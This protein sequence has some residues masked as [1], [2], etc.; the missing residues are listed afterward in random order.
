MSVNQNML[1]AQKKTELEIRSGVEIPMRDGT[2]LSGNLYLPRALPAQAPAIFGM[3]PYTADKH[4][5]VAARISAEGFPFLNVDVRGSGKSQGKSGNIRQWAQDGYDVAQWLASQPF[6]DGRV[7]M[8]GGSIRGF[9]QWA[10]AKERPPSLATIIPVASCF[11]GLDVPMRNNVFYS[12]GGRTVWSAIS[13]DLEFWQM[14]YRRWLVAGKPFS[15]I[16]TLIGKADPKFREAL[17]HP[18]PDSHWDSFNPSADQY[19]KID[20]PILTITGSYD[21][22][23]PGALEHY[24]QH[25]AHASESARCNHYLVIGPW[26]HLGTGVPQ[27]NVGGVAI[28][29]NG[30]ID[31]P[32]LLADWYRWRLRAG[33]KPGLLK[34]LVTY[35]VM[36]AD[37]WKWADTLDEITVAKKKLFLDSTGT[38]SD[39]YASGSLGAKIGKGPPDS[40][41]YDPR[42]R[43]GLEVDEEAR[44]DIKPYVDQS[45]F[46]ALHSRMLVYHSAPFEAEIEVS[47]FFKL[48]AW[49]S[50]DAPDTDLYASVHEITLDGQSIQLSTD[51]IRARYRQGLRQP[52]L[53]VN[54]DPLQYRFERFTFVS[55]RIKRGHRIRLVISPLGRIVDAAINQRNYNS[56]GAV[57]HESADVGRPVTVTL[58]HNE[59]FPSVLVVPLGTL[60]REK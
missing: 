9:N 30:V 57:A 14:T 15:Q 54:Q 17:Q 32:G 18:E 52:S 29:A 20:I 50:I 45:L 28:G 24:R 12:A 11:F 19:S 43:S 26:D 1:G 47:G 58:F 23:Q 56:G 31:M 10:T 41:T 2:L 49:L 13:E 16:D 25:I 60:E 34:K 38:A 51:V 36:G 5:A 40:Y 44:I 22:D 59:E 27:P 6:C 53:I 4:H 42:D 7:A 37:L 21:D 3:T 46:H 55:R 48:E 33:E 35:Y 39:I 8:Q